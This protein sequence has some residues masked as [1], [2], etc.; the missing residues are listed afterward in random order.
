MQAVTTWLQYVSFVVKC[1]V[2]NQVILISIGLKCLWILLLTKL[3]C[4]WMNNIQFYFWTSNNGTW[5]FFVHTHSKL[6]EINSQSIFSCG[7]QFNILYYAVMFPGTCNSEKCGLPFIFIWD[8]SIQTK[9]ETLDFISIHKPEGEDPIG[10][11]QN[12]SLWRTQWG[13][14]SFSNCFTWVE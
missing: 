12:Y 3:R 1:F 13:V 7:N 4:I 10:L 14:S 6:G 5:W 11:Q 8:N 2:I 9:N